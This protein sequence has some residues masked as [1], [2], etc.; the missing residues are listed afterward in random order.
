MMGAHLCSF[1]LFE[2]LGFAWAC[3]FG[4]VFKY[5]EVGIRDLCFLTS[6]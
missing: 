5:W 6:Y 2:P 4:L 3:L 1:S